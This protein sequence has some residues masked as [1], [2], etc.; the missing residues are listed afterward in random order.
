MKNK[1]EREKFLENYTEFNNQI[2][3]ISELGLKFFTHVF[4]NGAVVVATVNEAVRY[5]GKLDTEVRYRLILDETDSYTSFSFDPNTG[6]THHEFLR[7]APTGHSMSMIVDYMTKN[8]KQLR[9]ATM[10]MTYLYL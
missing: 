9:N 5:D 6:K 1:A 7:Y 2:Y 10:P 3:E 4:R 8:Y